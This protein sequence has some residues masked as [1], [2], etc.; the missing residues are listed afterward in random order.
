MKSSFLSLVASV[1]F[2]LLTSLFASNNGK[3]PKIFQQLSEHQSVNIVIQL[4]LDVGVGVIAIMQSF[5][6]FWDH[7][8]STFIRPCQCVLYDS[9]MYF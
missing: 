9:I 6:Y 4:K 7:L 3:V 2:Y 1:A 5:N 8:T